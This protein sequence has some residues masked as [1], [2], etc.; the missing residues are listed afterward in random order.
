MATN[1]VRGKDLRKLGYP[2]GVVIRVALETLDRHF[3]GKSRTFKLEV[4]KNVI[5]QQDQHFEDPRF[6][7]L[8]RE[9]RYKS[10][11]ANVDLLAKKNAP[12]S[13]F[14]I[15]GIEPGAIHQMQNALKLPIAVAG[16][17]M[18][19]AHFGYGLP[20]GGVLAANNAVMPY[21][22][23]LDIG[24][25]MS[26]TV[27]DLPLSRLE[28]DKDQFKKVLMDNTCFGQESFQRP[29]G[30]AVLDRK[31]FKEVKPISNL[32]NLAFRQMGSS[33]GGNHF[34]EFGEVEL[35]GDED[36]DLPRGKFVAILSHSGSRGLGA[37]LARYYTKIASLSCKLPEQASRLAWL[38]LDSEAG[39]EYWLAMELAGDYA[40]ACH[41]DIHRRLM[42]KIG[43][44]ALLNIENHHNFAW[45]ENLADGREVIVHRKG[46]TPAG[47][48]VLG[49][50]PGSMT[51]N[52]YIVKGK[53][54]AASLQ[55]ASHGAGREMS[56]SEA[57]M[58][59]TA[60]DLEAE[61][62]HAGVTLVGGGV[63]E[64]PYAYKDIDRVISHQDELIEVLGKFHPRI[65]RMAGKLEE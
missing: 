28:A 36:S 5:N 61:L 2:E 30:H 53:G 23:G 27:L 55:S 42:A 1:A 17:M 38:D 4:M 47:K 40:K 29:Q 54:N 52:G 8:I 14:G 59:V 57:R 58:H 19:D 45:K 35:Y 39:Q 3:S 31:E 50:I 16:A 33:G 11:A 32:A 22:V 49:I 20:I 41:D 64:S 7:L 24:C 43:G 34:V 62:V 56:R 12:C 48:G 9:L 13:I 65:V 26:L 60:E 44:Q 63:D 46:A 25:R 51:T 10:G 15:E 21:G 18:P 37:N 6:R